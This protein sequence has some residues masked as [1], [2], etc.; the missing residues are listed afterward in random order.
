MTTLH[1]ALAHAQAANHFYPDIWRRIDEVRADG[2]WPHWC[3][4][5]IGTVLKLMAEDPYWHSECSRRAVDMAQDA[6][7]LAS[8]AAWRTTQTIYRFDSSLHDLLRDADPTTRV[9]TDILLMLPEWS[10]YIETPGH[11]LSTRPFHGV[12]AHCEWDSR[13][14]GGSELRL[15]L[16]FQDELMPMAIPLRHESIPEALE[17]LG[18]NHP[19]LANVASQIV[20]MLLY[21]CSKAADLGEH[22]P[23]RPLPRHTKRGPRTFPAA[24]PTAVDVGVQIGSA[25]RAAKAA[26]GSGETG[27]LAGSRS[28]PRPHWRRWH[29]HTYWTGSGADR[30]MDLRWMPP[31]PVNI[32]AV[33]AAPAVIR[34][35]R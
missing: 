14:V 15:L 26:D 16:D 34:P 13:P 32:Q 18:V 12:F 10:I 23:L 5:P 1:S 31:I 33:D 21:I 27:A 19:E 25:L 29:W 3:F 7:R 24:A 4:V 22:R 35:V 2:T 11:T 30:R 9:P 28:S 8:I 6:A 20:S 17:A